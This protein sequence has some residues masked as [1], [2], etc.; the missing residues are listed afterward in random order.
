MYFSCVTNIFIY[1]STPFIPFGLLF[2]SLLTFWHCLSMWRGDFITFLLINK[3]LNNSFIIF[4]Y[5]K[6]AFFSSLLSSSHITFFEKSFWIDM[7]EFLSSFLLFKICC[8]IQSQVK[9]TS[10]GLDHP[11]AN[12][13]NL[14]I[15]STFCFC[16]SQLHLCLPFSKVGIFFNSVKLVGDFLPS[17][18]SVSSIGSI[19]KFWKFLGAV[20]I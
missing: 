6:F 12:F 8:F 9:P 18:I 7:P 19:S 5:C 13:P 2:Q 11:S 14:L 15:K 4:C 16:N 3:F 10:I 17:S 1:L 20:K